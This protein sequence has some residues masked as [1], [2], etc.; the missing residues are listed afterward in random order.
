MHSPRGRNAH[1]VFTKKIPMNSATTATARKNQGIS[2]SFV[3][4]EVYG[5]AVVTALPFDAGGIAAA[6]QLRS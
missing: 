4:C 5:R 3:R 6:E 2:L 1:Q